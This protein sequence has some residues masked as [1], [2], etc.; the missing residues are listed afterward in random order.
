MKKCNICKIEKN[1]DEFVKRL[2]RKSGIQAYCKKCH[3]EKRKLNANPKKIRNYDLK[4]SYGIDSLYY[5]KLFNDQ[6]GCCAICKIHISELNQKIKKYLCIDHDHN[7][8]KIRGLLC[9]KCNRG[10]GLLKDSAENLLSA[11]NYILKNT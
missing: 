2:N 9:D 5:D 6:N 11:Y 8:G 7:N 1:F 4:K 10:I 3:N